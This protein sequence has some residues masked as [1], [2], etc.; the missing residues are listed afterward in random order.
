MLSN[1]HVR[2]PVRMCITFAAKW[3]QAM[4]CVQC[5]LGCNKRTPKTS[6]THQNQ[7]NATMFT[8]VSHVVGCV[9]CIDRRLLTHHSQWR[10]QTANERTKREKKNGE[11][12]VRWASH[13]VTCFL[14]ISYALLCI[15]R[16]GAATF[17]LTLSGNCSVWI[18]HNN[19]NNERWTPLELFRK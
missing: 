9:L 8:H 1:F 14:A 16:V 17:F 19:T 5:S 15:W 12:V 6:W 11:E 13:S 7:C 10:N 3:Y 4:Q 2:T 18:F